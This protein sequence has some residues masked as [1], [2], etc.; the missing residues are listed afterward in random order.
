V[1]D[2]LNRLG[3][4]QRLALLALA[5]TLLITVAWWALAL[6]PVSAAPRWLVRTRYACFGTGASGLPD[7]GGWILLIGQPLSMLGFLFLVWGRAIRTGLR[8]LAARRGGRMALQSTVALLA[9]GVL[10]AA[11]SVNHARG[12]VIAGDA[13]AE[14]AAEVTR[15][16]R[17]APP[18]LLLDQHGEAFQLDRLRGRPVLVTF[19]WAHCETVCPLVVQD[20]LAARSQ[21]PDIEPQVVLVTLDPWRDT[22]PRLPAIAQKWRLGAGD[23][24]LSGAVADV[25]AALDAWG[26]PIQRDASTGAIDHVAVVYILDRAGRLAFAVPG[27]AQRIAALLRRS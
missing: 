16:D 2:R 21:V 26:V 3:S 8:T 19:A 9:A 4:G 22:P 15:L 7:A 14:S 5:A 25:V 1:E 27:G 11:W 10:L 17:S 23:Y 20:V 12:R 24:V 18:L 13:G 6:W